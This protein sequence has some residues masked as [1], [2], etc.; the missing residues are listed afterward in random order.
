LQITRYIHPAHNNLES[1]FNGCTLKRSHTYAL[2]TTSEEIIDIRIY[3][4]VSGTI[5]LWLLIVK[6]PDNTYFIIIALKQF[7][8]KFKRIENGCQTDIYINEE[9]HVLITHI[10]DNFVGKR[11]QKFWQKKREKKNEEK[12]KVSIHKYTHTNRRNIKNICSG[13]TLHTRQH[14]RWV[15]C[16]SLCSRAYSRHLIVWCIYLR[17]HRHFFNS[18]SSLK[19]E[20]QKKVCV[21][22][23]QHPTIE[24]EKY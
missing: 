14:Y 4:I 8:N 6:S 23:Q 21:P 2:F 7:E 13:S 15:V 16:V 5:S 18:M 11:T 3:K 9:V 10:K 20:R 24:R 1:L 17:S 22:S 12:E 19:K